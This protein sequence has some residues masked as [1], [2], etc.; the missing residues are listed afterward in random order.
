MCRRALFLW[1]AFVMA[2]AIILGL[3]TLPN[4]VLNTRRS[5]ADI[6]GVSTPV[7]AI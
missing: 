5:F 7:G 2:F 1:I 6:I 4:I 3:S